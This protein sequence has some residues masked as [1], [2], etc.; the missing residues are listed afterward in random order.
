MQTRSKKS[1]NRQKFPMIQNRMT[2]ML[3][4]IE[5]YGSGQKWNIQ[6]TLINWHKVNYKIRVPN[7]SQG[8]I[9]YQDK[10]KIQ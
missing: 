4:F 9:G 8:P 10:Q 2:R 5:F 3:V 1:G 6:K 7:G